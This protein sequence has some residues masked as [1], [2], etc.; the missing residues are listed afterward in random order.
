MAVTTTNSKLGDSLAWRILVVDDHP[1]TRRG[2]RALIEGEPDLSVCGEAAH[3]AVAMETVRQTRPHLVV[4]EL[5]LGS[6]DGLDLLK[7]LHS[8]HADTPVLVFSGRD[9]SL[10]AE[11]AF[12]AG[13]RG[14]VSKHEM[15]DVVIH[16]IR[17]VIAGERWMTERVA[18]LFTDRFLGTGSPRSESPLVPLSDRELQVLRLVG[19]GRSTRIVAAMLGISIK[20]VESHREHIKAKLGLDSASELARYAACW[21]HTGLTPENPAHGNSAEQ[22]GSGAARSD[23]RLLVPHVDGRRP[24]SRARAAEPRQAGER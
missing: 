5:M 24:S 4:L 16:A 17:R 6:S 15:P 23:V 18:R 19:E 12:R 3:A 2:L 1:I 10:Y 13:A 9:E 20:T 7:Q 21:V 11:R 22:H 14:F 8:R